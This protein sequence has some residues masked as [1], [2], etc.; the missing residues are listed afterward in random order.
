M[1]VFVDVNTRQILIYDENGVRKVPFHDAHILINIIGNKKI[2][3]VTDVMETTATEVVDLVRGISGQKPITTAQRTMP[4]D[5][6][7]TVKE[8]SYLH[9][10]S[11]G[12]LLIP[13]MDDKPAAGQKGHVRKAL[14][15]FE[16]R[17]DCK[18]FD[19][20]MKE[21]IKKSPLLRNLI[22]KGTIE[23]IGEQ[24]K[25]ELRSVTK[26]EMATK[27]AQQ[28]ARDAA[29]DAIIMDSKVGDWDGQIAGGDTAIEIDVGRR[30]IGGGGSGAGSPSH[31]A[32]SMSE[33]QSMIDGTM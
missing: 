31:G 23:M 12:T 6:E 16:G 27:V 2:N 9:S 25:N 14:I 7:E 18:L 33:L 8:A 15:R 29:L 28:S 11:N 17:G 5:L 3:Y 4:P 20:D 32:S 1:V 10:T 19:E 21:K 22:K 24:K 30:G 26:A 13:D